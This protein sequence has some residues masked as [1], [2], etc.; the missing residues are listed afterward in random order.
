MCVLIASFSCVY[1]TMLYYYY[2]Y[3]FFKAFVIDRVRSF[4]K[5]MLVMVMHVQSFPN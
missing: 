1:Y 2:Y 5:E 3:G 4:N